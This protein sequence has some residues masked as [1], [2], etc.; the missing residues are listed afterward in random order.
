MSLVIQRVS[1]HIGRKSSAPTCASPWATTFFANCTRL[2]SI[3]DGLL[4]VRDQVLTPEQ[5]VAF[6]Q[7]VRCKVDDRTR[8]QEP[9]IAESL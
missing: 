4:V 8:L 2:G 5:Q 1:P 6:S 3:G 9:E 7:Q